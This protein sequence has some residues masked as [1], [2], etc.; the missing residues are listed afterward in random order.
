MSAEWKDWS[1]FPE[2]C[3][4][5]L[6]REI[7]TYRRW[8]VSGNIHPDGKGKVPIDMRCILDPSDDGHLF[9]NSLKP[10][11]LVTLDTL[12]T[13]LPHAANCAFFVREE[14]D[15]VIVLDI[16]K[17]CEPD[18][19]KRL[20]AT[21]WEYG[22]VSMSGKGLHLAMHTPKALRDDF[23]DVMARK[24]CVKLFGGQ[25]EVMFEHW[26]TFTRNVIEADE[27]LG[28][29]ELIDIIRPEM[30]V[31]AAEKEVE[32]EYTDDRPEIPHEKSIKRAILLEPR[33]VPNVEDPTNHES[34]V[35]FGLMSRTLHRIDYYHDGYVRQFNEE[36]YTDN[37]RVWLLYDLCREMLPDRGKY[38][39]DRGHGMS[40]LFYDVTNCVKKHPYE[41]KGHR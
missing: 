32:I 33:Y 35:R 10:G 19:R 1:D 34:E 39:D 26:I 30:L 6:I 12:K 31:R 17:T 41:P 40:F 25:V 38:D 18:L 21:P 15:D 28:T 24:Q 7:G 27:T 29:V 9:G 23:G 5:P 37:Q 8:A 36:P 16:E 2:F 14:E 11:S 20:L 4:N 13:V 22:E 3:S